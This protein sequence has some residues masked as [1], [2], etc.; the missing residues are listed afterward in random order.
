MIG[1]YGVG[2]AFPM[3]SR[4]VSRLQSGVIYHYAVVMLLGLTLAIGLVALWD[5][6][7]FIVDPRFYFVFAITFL[8][9]TVI[10]LHGIEGDN[11]YK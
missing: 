2:Q 11:S 1:P 8:F 4:H 7:E 10:P 9:T 5:T 6:L 3:W